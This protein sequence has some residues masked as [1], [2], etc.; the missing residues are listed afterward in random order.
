[1]AGGAAAPRR[2]GGGPGEQ[3]LHFFEVA[4]ANAVRHGGGDGAAGFA[5]GADGDLQAQ[6]DLVEL[7]A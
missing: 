5:P 6:F 3:G 7:A 1:M 4:G 2:F